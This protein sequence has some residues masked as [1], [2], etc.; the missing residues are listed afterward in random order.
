MRSKLTELDLHN[1]IKR[2]LNAQKEAEKNSFQL[3]FSV[4]LELTKKYYP[5]ANPYKHQHW[6]EAILVSDFWE[7]IQQLT[8]LEQWLPEDR[9]RLV[10]VLG[11]GGVGKT[12]YI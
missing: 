10:A 1:T 3:L 2:I 4:D 12:S 5:Q 8:R 9:C 11:M 6:K 7:C